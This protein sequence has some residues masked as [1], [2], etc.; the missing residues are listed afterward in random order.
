MV[1]LQTPSD[2]GAIG[3]WYEDFEQVSDEEVVE[4]LR[5]SRPDDERDRRT[6]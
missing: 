4:L 6:G 1:C 5:S 3:L 2:L